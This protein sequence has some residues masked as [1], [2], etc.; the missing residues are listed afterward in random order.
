MTD[1]LTAQQNVEDTQQPARIAVAA[2]AVTVRQ[3]LADGVGAVAMAEEL[4][5]NRQR[6]YAMAN[7]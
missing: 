7:Q 6:V 1:V 5:L 4:G 3:A 2:R